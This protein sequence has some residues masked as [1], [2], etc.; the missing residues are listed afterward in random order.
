MFGDGEA[1]TTRTS[2][3]ANGWQQSLERSND[4]AALHSFLHFAAA[5][6]GC[7]TKTPIGAQTKY[8]CPARTTATTKAHASTIAIARARYRTMERSFR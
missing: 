1:W 6:H 4:G 2:S 5:Q 8:V 7:S 3:S